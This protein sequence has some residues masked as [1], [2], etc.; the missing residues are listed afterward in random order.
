MTTSAITVIRNTKGPLT[1]SFTLQDGRL[2]KAAAADLAVGVADRVQVD[3]LCHLAGILEGL[4]SS[5]ALTFG[6]C[7]FAKTRIV[8]RKA[9]HR[10]ARGAVYR[11]RDHFV[12]AER[13]GHL[14]TRHRQAQRRQRA[15]LSRQ[16]STP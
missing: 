14:L 2:K 3:D 4:N 15:D 5:E 1:K 13:S 10:G 16:T 12:L 9:F 8:T 6:V 7:R 11:G